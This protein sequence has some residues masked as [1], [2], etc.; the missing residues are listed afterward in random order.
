M[1]YYRITSTKLAFNL[2]NNN[3]LHQKPHQAS[4]YPD[5][6]T[7]LTITHFHDNVHE[8]KRSDHRSHSWQCCQLP[9]ATS[10][11]NSGNTKYAWTQ[12]RR[13]CSDPDDEG[14]T[15][16]RNVCTM[17]QPRHIPDT[18]ITINTNESTSNLTQV[19]KQS[20]VGIIPKLQW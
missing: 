19:L 11:T 8:C 7:L 16:L 5:Y 17:Y 6:L 3:T 4:K 20:D 15:Q 12:R 2:G 18:G 10:P 1:N 13:H 14:S 9:W